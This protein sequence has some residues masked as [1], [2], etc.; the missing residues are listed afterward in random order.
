MLT[1]CGPPKKYSYHA[2]VISGEMKHFREE[3]LVLRRELGALKSGPDY[4]SFF[5]S[6]NDAGNSSVVPRRTRESRHHGG[7]GVRESENNFKRAMRV[8]R[9]SLMNAFGNDE[10]AME[11]S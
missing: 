11:Y 6:H 9:S 8:R 10:S 1:W 5:G 2:C 4:G 7:H 3:M